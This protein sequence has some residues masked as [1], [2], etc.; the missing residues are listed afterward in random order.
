MMTRRQNR[1]F[2]DTMGKTGVYRIGEA[3]KGG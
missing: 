3:P 2:G 1:D